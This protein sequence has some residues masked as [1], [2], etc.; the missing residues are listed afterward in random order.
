MGYESQ[1]AY[2]IP[3]RRAGECQKALECGIHTYVDEMDD[4]VNT[5]YAGWPTRLYLI[6]LDVRVEYASEIGPR[7]VKPAELNRAI[8]EYL[9]TI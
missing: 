9:A 7:G 8:D 6:G 3:F 5:A 1:L 4:V 2:R